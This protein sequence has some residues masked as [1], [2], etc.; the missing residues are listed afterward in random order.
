MTTVAAQRT[1][2]GG[3]LTLFGVGL[4]LS[5]AWVLAVAVFQIGS[6]IL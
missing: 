3:R 6:L 1:E 5:L 2:I 4:Q